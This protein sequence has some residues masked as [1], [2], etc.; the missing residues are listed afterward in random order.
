MSPRV[1]AF[2]SLV[3][4]TML[5]L[6][7][8]LF[9]GLTMASAVFLSSILYAA[10]VISVLLVS[11]A[12]KLHSRIATRLS[13]VACA[14]AAVRGLVDAWVPVFVVP[15]KSVFGAPFRY[16][17]PYF[18]ADVFVVSLAV[19]LSFAVDNGTFERLTTTVF[20][21]NL[22]IAVIAYVLA[23]GRVHSGA[24]FLPTVL[25]MVF[26]PVPALVLVTLDLRWIRRC[27]VSAIFSHVLLLVMGLAVYDYEVRVTRSRSFKPCAMPETPDEPP[28]LDPPALP[29]PGQTRRQDMLRQRLRYRSKGCVVPP[30]SVRKASINILFSELTR[31]TQ[32]RQAQEPIADHEGQSTSMDE[33]CLGVRPKT[34]VS[35]APPLFKGRIQPSRIRITDADQRRQP[36]AQSASNQASDYRLR[37]QA[38]SLVSIIDPNDEE[39]VPAFARLM[40][41]VA[42]RNNWPKPAAPKYERAAAS[43]RP[44]SGQAS[45]EDKE[46]WRKWYLPEPT[47]PDR[48]RTPYNFCSRVIDD[49]GEE[50]WP[51]QWSGVRERE[52]TPYGYHPKSGF[53]RVAY[54]LAPD[55]IGTVG[56]RERAR[57]PYSLV[58]HDQEWTCVPRPKRLLALPAPQ[59]DVTGENDDPPTPSEK[60][61]PLESDLDDDSSDPLTPSDPVPT[62]PNE[63][64]D[65]PPPAAP[66][67]GKRA[68]ECDLSDSPSKRRC[69]G[70]TEPQGETGSA[71]AIEANAADDLVNDSTSAVS[72][73]PDS[74]LNTSLPR[75]S[76]PLKR[77]H[78]DSSP[79]TPS[80]HHC[81]GK[82]S[83]YDT[84]ATWT[85]QDAFEG[86]PTSL[87][88][89]I[90]P[91]DENNQSNATLPEGL[92]TQQPESGNLL[93]ASA[94]AV[95][96]PTASA[97]FAP[98]S[99]SFAD[100]F[101]PPPASSQQPAILSST[102]EFN[103]GSYLD[104]PQ[105][106]GQQLATGGTRP[107]FWVAPEFLEQNQHLLAELDAFIS[108]LPPQAPAQVTVHYT[109]AQIG[110]IGNTFSCPGPASAGLPQLDA[111]TDMLVDQAA[112]EIL[113]DEF[114]AQGEMEVDE[115]DELMSAWL[116]P[117]AFAM[118]HDA[119]E[120]TSGEPIEI[121]MEPPSAPNQGASHTP[122]EMSSPVLA[123]HELPGVSIEVDHL[124]QDE[125]QFSAVDTPQPFVAYPVSDPPDAAMTPAS[126]QLVGPLAAYMAI[127]MAQPLPQSPGDVD[128]IEDEVTITGAVASA[129]YNEPD[130]TSNHLEVKDVL[131]TPP[132]SQTPNDHASAPV[133]D[134]EEDDLATYEETVEEGGA[135]AAAADEFLAGLQAELTGSGPMGFSN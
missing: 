17:R 50:K 64:L 98:L 62:I 109:G 113:Q 63:L 16:R 23:T 77:A 9:A 89:G 114:E 66:I 105:P 33:L 72:T 34:Y 96:S 52:R 53:A 81:G 2:L 21:A 118:D 67:T 51:T 31:P 90:H 91:I 22:F 115:M 38:P 84:D 37:I 28:V 32:K 26:I 15:L 130:P 93:A 103:P 47:V 106:F 78:D 71:S 59:H 36:A 135:V 58:A 54:V 74:S 125:H 80:K 43:F 121:D 27:P 20:L 1:S 40:E 119:P 29:K 116:T 5:W 131:V 55:I 134:A 70:I 73:T 19:P 112:R 107:T 39:Q 94:A 75:R 65:Y 102:G 8:P 48:K 10:D 18:V 123:A 68:R 11:L 79:D 14:R 117:D 126:P 100:S 88:L 128:E 41:I 85:R 69:D 76:T 61:S 6:F 3:V 87:P 82:G 132:G 45:A 42:H 60:L 7:I 57:T 108:H 101:V 46:R 30:G 13:S 111:E 124:M 97:A 86:N 120:H 83:G 104:A 44:H 127:A 110:G 4:T 95:G 99:G 12:S 122:M 25:G 129:A 24:V 133:A 49:E 56:I 35:S 92:S